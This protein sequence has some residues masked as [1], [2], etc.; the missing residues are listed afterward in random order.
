MHPALRRIAD[1]QL[2]VIT[3]ADARRAGYQHPEIRRLRST[4]TWVQ[5]RRGVYITA[6]ELADA[7]RRGRRHDV[8]CLAV[9]LS[10]GRTTAAISHG[11]AARL[12]RLP[13][14]NDPDPTIRLTDPTLWRRGK[15]FLISPA[16]LGPAE[17]AALGPIR[18]TSAARTLIDCAREWRLVDAVVAMDA[19][20]LAQRT[21]AEDSRQQRPRHATGGEQAL[22]RVRWPWRT[23][24]RSPRWR[25]GGASGSS[26]RAF[27][28]RSC[29]WRSG[30]PAGSSVS[31]M[32]GSRTRRSRSSSTGR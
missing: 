25:R 6:D 23:A 29:R 27:P 19:A 16:P 26:A 28:L 2:G 5:L 9:L 14:P 10:L 4:G 3:A 17:L 11:S 24:G 21:T 8:D 20:L 7:E 30:R 31:S 32:R 22:R 1:R 13:V 15:D 12:W 18:V